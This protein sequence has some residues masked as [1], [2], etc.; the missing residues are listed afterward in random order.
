M[1]S[2]NDFVNGNLKGSHH[3]TEHP[4]PS[5]FKMH[6]HDTY[7]LYYFIGGSGI[8]RVEGTPY[9]LQKGDILI[10]RPTEAHY[11]DITDN[12][13]YTRLSVNFKTGLLCGIDPSGKLLAPLTIAKSAPL[14]DTVRKILRVTLTAF[15]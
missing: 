11:I 6:T 13:P 2:V 1:G 10:M 15:L 9:P 12:K 5:D 3:I 4:N 14:T 8:Y 7:E